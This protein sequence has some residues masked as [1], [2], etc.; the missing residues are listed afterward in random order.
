MSRPRAALA[1]GSDGERRN[2]L[3]LLRPTPPPALNQAFLPHFRRLPHQLKSRREGQDRGMR[4]AVPGIRGVITMRVARLTA[5]GLVAGAGLWI[6]SGHFLPHAGGEKRAAAR[7]VHSE[8]N[9]FRVAVER[10]SL[11]PHRRNL[12]ISGRTEADRHV[13]I[14]ARASGVL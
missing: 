11:V 7:V 4:G 9:V 5:I 10:T 3:R 1:S 6:A 2:A 13:A 14:T 8:P 12:A